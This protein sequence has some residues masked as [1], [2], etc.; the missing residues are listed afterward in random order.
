MRVGLDHHGMT[1]E[2]TRVQARQEKQT[3]RMERLEK[4]VIWKTLFGFYEVQIIQK[5][6]FLQILRSE[7][8]V[9]NFNTLIVAF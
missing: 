5:S 1:L 9:P 7:P 4:C 3:N 6:T 8:V 2:N